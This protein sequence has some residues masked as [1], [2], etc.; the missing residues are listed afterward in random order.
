MLQQ[1]GRGVTIPLVLPIAD[2]SPHPARADIVRLVLDAWQKVDGGNYPGSI[3]DTRKALE[4]IRALSPATLPLPGAAK[5]R[6][7][8]QRIRAVVDALFGLASASAHVDG[9]IKTF[10]PQRADAVALTAATAA[11]AQEIFARLRNG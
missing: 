10:E 3:S 11:I 1:W 5:D 6:D 9:P 4:L 8:D 7:V 2:A